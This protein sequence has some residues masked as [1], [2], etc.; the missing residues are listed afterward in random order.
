MK[1]YVCSYS[2]QE[3]EGGE[4]GSELSKVKVL[5]VGM[6]SHPMARD[7]NLFITETSLR[8][9]VDRFNTE[10]KPVDHQLPVD[11]NHS[12]KHAEFSG[13]SASSGRSVGWTSELSVETDDLGTFLVAHTDFTEEARGRIEAKEYRY[14]SS[15]FTHESLETGDETVMPNKFRMFSLV[16]NPHLKDLGAISLSEGDQW[17]PV[18]LTEVIESTEEILEPPPME[19]AITKDTLSKGEIM[20][21]KEALEKNAELNAAISEKDRQAVELASSV[22]A[23][24]VELKE[25]NDKVAEL[26]DKLKARDEEFARITAD[27]KRKEAETFVELKIAENYVRPASREVAIE[28]YEEKGEEFFG[29]VYAEKLGDLEVAGQDDEP[30]DG[31]DFELSYTDA[32]NAWAEQTKC[33]YEDACLQIAGDSKNKYHAS[34][35]KH[36]REQRKGGR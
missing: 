32:A 14:V 26:S 20:E 6:Y 24:Q 3:G 7:G 15:V 30:S 23:V 34:Y 31:D 9:M 1:D 21:L 17:E 4:A 8:E 13:E 10:D 27:Q 22:E 19:A 36:Y 29:K 5:K 16:N 2:L 28:L 12:M 35:V 18:E 33:S 11:F 25:A